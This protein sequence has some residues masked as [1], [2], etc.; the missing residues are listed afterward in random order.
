MTW[1]YFCKINITC[2]NGAIHNC[3]SNLSASIMDLFILWWSV[4][5]FIMHL[6]FHWWLYFFW[7]TQNRN[8][9]NFMCIFVLDR[10]MSTLFCSFTV[11]YLQKHTNNWT[12]LDA[13]GKVFSYGTF[14]NEDTYYANYQMSHK[15]L[16][17]QFVFKVSLCLTVLEIKLCHCDFSPFYNISTVWC[18]MYGSIVRQNIMIN[19]ITSPCILLYQ[20]INREKV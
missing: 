13:P 18:H 7:A 9:Q 17:P 15:F 10:W 4:Q 20:I 5:F 12:L 1:K 8:I 11:Q 3:V 14:Q 2:L 19:I 6:Q 16:G